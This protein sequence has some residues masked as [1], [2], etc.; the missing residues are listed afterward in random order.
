[1]VNDNDTKPE[2]AQLKGLDENMESASSG[3]RLNVFL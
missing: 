2:A 3:F 1:M